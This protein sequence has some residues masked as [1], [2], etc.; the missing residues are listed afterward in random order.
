MSE[1]GR[2]SAVFQQVVLQCCIVGVCKRDFVAVQ[3]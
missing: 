3:H 1:A 2:V